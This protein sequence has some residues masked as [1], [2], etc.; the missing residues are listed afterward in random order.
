MECESRKD[1]AESDLTPSSGDTVVRERLSGCDDESSKPEENSL[2]VFKQL[3][4]SMESE[5]VSLGKLLC[6]AFFLTRRGCGLSR[7]YD[8]SS[9]FERVEHTEDAGEWAEGGELCARVTEDLG[10]ISVESEEDNEN[11]R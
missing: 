7:L 4:L 11:C 3:P 2:C 6:D 9:V 10:L 8:S 1:D 5:G